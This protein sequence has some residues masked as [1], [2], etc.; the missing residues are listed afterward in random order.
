MAVFCCWTANSVDVAAD[1]TEEILLD[2]PQPM[3]QVGQNHGYILYRSDI[4][5]QYYEERLA[6][7]WRLMTAV[8]SMLIKST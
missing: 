1:I 5:N 8:I 6:K 2:Y 3:E 4:K 7:P